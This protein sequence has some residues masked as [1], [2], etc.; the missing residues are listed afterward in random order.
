[1]TAG[2][3]SGVDIRVLRRRVGAGAEQVGHNQHVAGRAH[4]VDLHD[5]VGH[6]S[7]HVEDADDLSRL[8]R[9][10]HQALDAAVPSGL[11]TLPMIV[12]P[13]AVSW[14]WFQ[15]VVRDA[16]IATRLLASRPSWPVGVE[17]P[18]P[19]PAVPCPVDE[20]QRP[21]IRAPRERVLRDPRDRHRRGVPDA[22]GPVRPLR[23]GIQVVNTGASACRRR[24]ASACSSAA[25]HG[26]AAAVWGDG[27]VADFCA[28]RDGRDGQRG[29]G[30]SAHRQA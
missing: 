24:S 5:V 28:G 20:G 21:V 19:F 16:G 2:Q 27:E 11:F 9:D 12:C 25:Y 8:G 26:Q 30:H 7:G 10:L 23:P 22:A 6:A 3:H 1:M 4:P 17:E 15:D 18:H 29:Q 13:S 14:I